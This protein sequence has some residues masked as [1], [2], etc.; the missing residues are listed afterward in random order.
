MSVRSLAFVPDG[1][2][3]KLAD[4]SWAQLLAQTPLD[5]NQLDLIDKVQLAGKSLPCSMLQQPK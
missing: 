3:G 2:L 1:E 4:Q 5:R